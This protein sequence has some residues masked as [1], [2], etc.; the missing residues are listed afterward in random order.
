MYSLKNGYSKQ[1]IF[2]PQGIKHGMEVLSFFEAMSPYKSLADNAFIFDFPLSI[3]SM[4]VSC[5]FAPRTPCQKI[6]I[7]SQMRLFYMLLV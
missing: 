1:E 4:R 2:A 6:H 3:I 5:H 7:R